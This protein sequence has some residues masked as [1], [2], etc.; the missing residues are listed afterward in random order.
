MANF[1]S[2]EVH[3]IGKKNSA[4]MIYASMPCLEE[5]E[6]IYESGTDDEYKLNFTGACKWSVNYGVTDVPT[7][8]AP[9][10]SE[11][12]R[13]QIY[14]EGDNY[15]GFSLRAKSEMFHCEIQVHYWSEES[16]F[17]QFDQYVNGECVKSRETDIYI[18][19]LS[20]MDFLEPTLQTVK[21]SS[22]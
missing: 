12:T 17:D 20:G 14:K 16:E 5:K 7:A 13:E 9:D 1:C 18:D 2:Y 21:A 6:I 11:L 8:E 19:M 22:I 4:I 15:W 3:V 10:I